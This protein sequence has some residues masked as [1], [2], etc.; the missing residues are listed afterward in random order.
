MRTL[1]MLGY[2]ILFLVLGLLAYIRL[3][4]SDPDRWHV[5]VSQSADADMPNGAV[6]I[7]PAGPD[8]LARVDAAARALPRTTVL[9]GSVAEGRITYVTRS[10]AFGFPDYTTVE[11]SDGMVK[12]FARQRFGRSDFGVNRARLERL[13]AAVEA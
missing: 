1:A 12:M 5:A 2:V 11:Q 3:A 10:A 13:T 9:E 7:L 8:T 4:P 6:R